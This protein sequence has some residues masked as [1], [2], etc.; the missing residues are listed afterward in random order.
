M[1]C[2]A[3]VPLGNC[4]LARNTDHRGEL[5]TQG[6]PRRRPLFPL[7][8]IVRLAP[9]TSGKLSHDQRHNQHNS[10]GEEVSRLVNIE[11]VV[12]RHEAEV[13]RDN[14]QYA[15]QERGPPMV[16]VAYDHDGE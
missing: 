15:G 7:H 10:K 16:A 4:D 1:P 5:A 6:K 2:L 13:E 9:D 8:G 11:G 12:R 3:D 14:A